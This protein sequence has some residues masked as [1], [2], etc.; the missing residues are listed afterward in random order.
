MLA[1]LNTWETLGMTHQEKET[2]N[3]RIPAY[4]VF[5]IPPRDSDFWT[6][7]FRGKCFTCWLWFHPQWHFC[8]VWRATGERSQER[9]WLN[10]SEPRETEWICSKSGTCTHFW[11]IRC[12]C[13][14]LTGHLASHSSWFS[15]LFTEGT[16]SILIRTSVHL[17]RSQSQTFPSEVSHH[18]S[19]VVANPGG[20]EASS[21]TSSRSNFVHLHWRAL[22]SC[23]VVLGS[24]TF[25]CTE[26]CCAG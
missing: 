14:Q 1:N 24:F 10:I 13:Q 25:V 20:G 6:L 18:L 26:P 21:L 23:C 3:R 4:D 17:S 22:D 5:S 12:T 9:S 2:C 16:L 15:H 11:T 8:G 7:R 19:F